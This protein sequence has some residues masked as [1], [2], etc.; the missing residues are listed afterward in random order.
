M[1]RLTVSLYAASFALA[2]GL[3][4]WSHRRPGVVAP[5]GVLL[6]RILASRAGRFALITF[7]WWLGWHF[8]V[9]WE[10]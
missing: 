10:Q 5:A 6:D 7:W 2:I 4:L 8:L 9:W 1:A 3:A